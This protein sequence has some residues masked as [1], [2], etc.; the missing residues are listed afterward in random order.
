MRTGLCAV[1]FA[2]LAVVAS[3]A[4]GAN[5]TLTMV[6]G[7]GGGG[8][9]N[10]TAFGISHDAPAGVSLTQMTFTVGDTQYLFDQLYLS[11]EQFVGGNGT[12]AATLLI[13]D[14]TDDNAGPDLFRYGFTNLTAGIVFR[15]QW[16]IDNDNGDFNADMRQVFFNNGAAPNAVASFEFSDGSSIVY[17]FPDLASQSSYSIV[18]PGPGAM[19]VGVLGALAAVRRRR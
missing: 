10:T 1:S 11:E 18:I 12:Q 13:G 4:S 8:E 14:R 2:A 7:N 9:F 16:D 5:V 15:G 6:N 3:A 17:Q 19:A